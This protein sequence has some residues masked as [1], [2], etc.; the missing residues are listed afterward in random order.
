[1]KMDVKM[2]IQVFSPP[3]QYPDDGTEADPDSIYSHLVKMTVGP[4]RHKRRDDDEF[5]DQ[6]DAGSIEQDTEVFPAVS[7]LVKW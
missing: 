6:D 2:H 5:A 3:L 4:G 7:M 1:M